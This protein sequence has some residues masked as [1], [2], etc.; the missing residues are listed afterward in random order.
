MPGKLTLGNAFSTQA[1]LANIS[2]AEERSLS[3]HFGGA[4]GV[5]PRHFAIHEIGASLL[6]FQRGPF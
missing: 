4:D 1:K 2:N 6:R 3:F 5:I